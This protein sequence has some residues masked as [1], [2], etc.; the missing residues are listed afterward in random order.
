ME[1]ASG[2][3]ITSFLIKFL[4]DIH[5]IWVDLDYGFQIRIDLPRV[6]VYVDCLDIDDCRRETQT[7]C[8]R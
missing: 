6:L 5:G 3:T 1:H 2:F 8:I 4:G 7:Q